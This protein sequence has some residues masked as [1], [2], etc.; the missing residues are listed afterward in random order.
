MKKFNR[1]LFVLLLLVSGLHAQNALTLQQAMELGMK[2]NFDIRISQT[3][4][5]TE[6]VNNTLGNAGM[7]PTV[8]LSA[9]GSVENNDEKQVLSS[10]T[11]NHYPSLTSTVLSSNIQLNW[12]LFDGGKM[13]VTKSKL[14][15]IEQLGQLKFKNHVLASMYDIIAAYYNIVRQQ[16]Q[17][18]SIQEVLK[19]NSERLKIS[20]AGFRA[21]SLMRPDVLQ[22]QMDENSIRQSI[23]EQQFQINLAKR[24]LN[25][26]LGRDANTVF[27]ATDSIST[28]TLPD[29]D[30]INTLINDRNTDIKALEAQTEI[31]RKTIR[32]SQSSYLPTLNLKAGYYYSQTD[33]SDGSVR[34]YRYNGPQALA[35]LTIPVFN[36][37][38]TQRK[39]KL[40]KLARQNTEISLEQLRI[41]ILNEVENAF[42][43]MENQSQLLE[44]ETTNY[45]MAE[46]NLQ[47]SL[48]RFSRG[49]ATSLEV[50]Q[51][52]ENFVQ[53]AT[54]LFTFRY[55]LKLSETRIRQLSA[56][57]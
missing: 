37:G 51:A 56:D 39:V 41:S 12:T 28:G 55:N 45:Q 32:E 26:L 17:L 11:T 3:S 52:Q 20:Q 27:E 43:D 40:A 47:I 14:N 36:A 48:Q 5:E 34:N 35:T 10:G 2:N 23:I 24:D 16:M 13:F 1:I 25:I 4:A 44:I 46:E 57:L 15:D 33:N 6:K 49:Q 53:S 21:G 31:D 30:K 18:K 29:K 42:Q 54:R 8:A 7:L 22:A 50:H 9:T 19:Y 38:E